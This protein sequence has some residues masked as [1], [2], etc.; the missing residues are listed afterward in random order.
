MRNTSY[1]TNLPHTF[2]PVL[3][4]SLMPVMQQLEAL[5]K[6]V[7]SFPE[8]RIL[9][10]APVTVSTQAHAELFCCHGAWADAA[11]G[12]WLLDGHG[13]W[14]SIDHNDANAQDVIAG[15]HQKIKSL[16]HERSKVLSEC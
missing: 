2:T 11:Q 8:G 15:I 3:K 9:F 14:H 16:N 5:K 4:K 13:Q 6:Q 7:L 10:D 1:K 12:L